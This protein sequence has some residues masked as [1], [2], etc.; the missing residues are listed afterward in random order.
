MSFEHNLD[1]VQNFSHQTRWVAPYPQ[2]TSSIMST[3]PLMLV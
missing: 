3:P 2:Y 1:Y